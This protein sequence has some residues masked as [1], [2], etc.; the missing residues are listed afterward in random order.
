MDGSC[1]SAR[2]RNRKAGRNSAILSQ[3][4]TSPSSADF[5]SAWL[6][7]RIVQVGLKLDRASRPLW[8]ARACTLTSRGSRIAFKVSGTIGFVGDSFGTTSFAPRHWLVTG[9]DAS[10]SARGALTK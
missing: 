10:P 7:M 8:L 6:L 3:K 2:G 5:T 1:T 9:R 4:P